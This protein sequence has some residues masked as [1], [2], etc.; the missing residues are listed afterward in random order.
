MNKKYNVD[1]EGNV[2]VL[3]EKGKE[4]Q[5]NDKYTKNTDEILSLE[6]LSEGLE[7]KINNFKSTLEELKETNKDNKNNIV[8]LTLLFVCGLGITFISPITLFLI[9]ILAIIATIISIPLILT[10]IK[11]L[12]TNNKEIN[13]YEKRILENSYKVNKIKKR[14]ATLLKEQTPILQG[15]HNE[16]TDVKSIYNLNLDPIDYFI[17]NYQIGKR[18]NEM[19]HSKK[20]VR[21]LTTESNSSIYKI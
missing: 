11:K 9:K 18:A 2:I 15:N 3:N 6:N 19:K 8:I 4:I 10:E 17:E 1:L 12:I 13:K 5:R 21:K 7:N 14:I 20:K 16:F